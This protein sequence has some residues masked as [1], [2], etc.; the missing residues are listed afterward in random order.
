MNILAINY[1]PTI[2]ICYQNIYCSFCHDMVVTQRSQGPL[3]L[4]SLGGVDHGLFPRRAIAKDFLAQCYI[5][6]SLSRAWG[7]YVRRKAS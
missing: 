4:F 5:Q 6:C 3:F 1:T 7:M 2:W